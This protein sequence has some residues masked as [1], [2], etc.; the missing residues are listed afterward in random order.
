MIGIL[1]GEKME[2]KEIKKVL[3]GR[4]IETVTETYN[5]ELK[6]SLLGGG[7]VCLNKDID[8]NWRLLKS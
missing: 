1:G 4:A 5:G 6:L 2:L 7:S 8:G 3:E